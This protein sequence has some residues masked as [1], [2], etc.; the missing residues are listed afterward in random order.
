M[1]TPAERRTPLSA[2][3]GRRLREHRAR[4]GLSQEALAHFAGLST[5][6]V[7]SV[8]R[9]ERNV[10]LEVV[11]RLASKLGV[12]PGELVRGLKAPRAR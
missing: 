12:D 8:E 4:R 1:R 9:G 7:A 10:S 6:Y 11:V 5:T 2:E 3:F